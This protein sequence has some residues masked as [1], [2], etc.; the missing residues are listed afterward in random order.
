M[1]HLL[2]KHCGL[3]A[4]EFVYFTGNCHLYEDHFEPMKEIFNR[5]PFEFPT[6]EIANIKENI[7]DYQVSDFIISNYQSHD[8][9]KMKM[10]A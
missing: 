2:A 10:V 5:T 7:N 8:V 9:I 4:Y 3:E 6:L 1:T